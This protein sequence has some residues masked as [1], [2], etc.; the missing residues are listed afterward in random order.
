LKQPGNNH[1]K[2]VYLPTSAQTF[3]NRLIGYNFTPS[4]AC[5]SLAAYCAAARQVGKVP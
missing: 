1:V 3:L 4:I 5:V 2:P